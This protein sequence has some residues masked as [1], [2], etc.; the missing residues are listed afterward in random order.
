MDLT[1]AGPNL[2]SGSTFH[3]HK[4]GCADLKRKV[5]YRGAQKWDG[6]FTSLQDVVEDVFTDHMGENDADSPYSKWEAYTGE[7]DIFPCVGAL[8]DVAP[9]ATEETSESSLPS[10]LEGDKVTPSKA[11][12]KRT[13]TKE[14][15]VSTKT[16]TNAK[17]R[18]TWTHNNA[19]KAVSLR[20]K[21]MSWA[22]IGAEFNV[23][24][25]TARSMFDHIKGEG[26]HYEHR[27]EGKGGRIRNGVVLD[28]E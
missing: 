15:P 5:V 19:R 3:V 20:N 18:R 23:S 1:I 13:A 28:S 26:A 11:V 12:A 17:N 6:D 16:K 21:G 2:A 27:L 10:E 22:Q 25:R 7:F 9:V 8:P 4:A 24:P 14:A